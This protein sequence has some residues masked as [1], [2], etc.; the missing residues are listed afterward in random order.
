VAGVA[1]QRVAL[2]QR[3]ATDLPERDELVTSPRGQQLAVGRAG[4]PQDNVG[5]ALLGGDLLERGDRPQAD[6]LIGA[7]AGQP[8]TVRAECR[9]AAIVI[10]LLPGGAEGAQDA[11]QLPGLE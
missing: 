7:A 2:L 1:D 10:V 5:V 3:A 9:E 11:D 8:A 4:Q 6:N